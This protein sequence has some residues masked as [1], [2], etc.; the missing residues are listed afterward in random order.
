MRGARSFSSLPLLV[1]VLLLGGPAIGA[2]QQPP[3]IAGV[4]GTVALEG[5][6]DKAYAGANAIVVKAADGIEHLFHFTKRTVVHGAAATDEAFNGLEAGTRV[7]VH[8]AV[9]AGGTT[10]VE[11]DRI[12]DD[13]MREMRGVVTRVDRG[14]KRLSIGLADGSNETLQLSECAARDVGQDVGDAA[15]VVVYYT[16]E[17]GRKLAH[18]FGKIHED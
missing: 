18:Y 5:T 2:A 17:G 7:V 6:V 4:T 3:P 13:G 14:A 8:Y 12:G 9:E 16:D 15:T 1:A 10:A 11:V